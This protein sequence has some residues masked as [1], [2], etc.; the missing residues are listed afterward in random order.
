MGVENDTPPSSECMHPIRVFTPGA[1]SACSE[2]VIS[3][4]Q[5]VVILLDQQRVGNNVMF[6]QKY[7]I[8]VVASHLGDRKED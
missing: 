1:N 5:L 2:F 6:A 4:L 7:C 8:L 3:Q